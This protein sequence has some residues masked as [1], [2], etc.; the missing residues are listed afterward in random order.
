MNEYNTMQYDAMRYDA[1]HL[2]FRLL[3]GGLPHVVSSQLMSSHSEVDGR[4]RQLQMHC[5]HL[6]TGFPEGDG[7]YSEVDLSVLHGG[8][9]GMVDALQ[10]EHVELHSSKHVQK[11]VLH[12][13]VQSVALP[14]GTLENEE[15]LG[16]DGLL[17]GG[18]LGHAAE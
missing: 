1:V 2:R 8:H 17:W 18:E 5:G 15:G 4:A 13:A 7:I 14:L 12:A 3:A 9:K 11:Q 10:R 6:S 16:A